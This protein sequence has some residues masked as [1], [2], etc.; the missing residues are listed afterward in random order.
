M[1]NALEQLVGSM[2]LAELA[3]KSRRSVDQI[4]SF[5]M[6]N[7]VTSGKKATAQKASAKPATHGNAGRGGKVNTRSAKGR[8][9]YEQAV[10][11]VV[12]SANGRQVSAVDIRS[13]V[14]G[15]PMQARAALNRLIEDGRVAY[16]GVARATKY[17]V[18]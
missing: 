2:T 6:A 9:A 18:A 4:V 13:K 11:D 12:A 5:A 15:T 17:S 3:S 14:G 16:T 7:G 1:S 10:Y 8:A